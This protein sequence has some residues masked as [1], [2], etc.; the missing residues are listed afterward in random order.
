MCTTSERGWVW[1]RLL[2]MAEVSHGVSCIDAVVM[3]E[4]GDIWKVFRFGYW[5]PNTFFI[6]AL[7]ES[8]FYTQFIN[9]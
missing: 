1:V 9:L 3:A 2:K 4:M 7:S 6:C 8:W 5:N